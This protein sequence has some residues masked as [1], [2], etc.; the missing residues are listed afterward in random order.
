MSS[1]DGKSTLS[2]KHSISV[3]SHEKHAHS[4]KRWKPG[5]NAGFQGGQLVAVHTKRP[6][7]R[8]S[9]ELGHQLEGMLRRGIKKNKFIHTQTHTYACWYV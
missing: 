9:R 7:S 6:V 8:R 2:L 1:N 5:K 3:L 4:P